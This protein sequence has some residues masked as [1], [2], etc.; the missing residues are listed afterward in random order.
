[1]N[2]YTKTTLEIKTIYKM[3]Q[4]TKKGKDLENEDNQTTSKTK[5]V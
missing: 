4:T 3:K 5:M 1:M 2:L